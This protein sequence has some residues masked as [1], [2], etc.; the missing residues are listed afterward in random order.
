[1]SRSTISTMELFAMFPDEATARIYLESRLWAEGVNCPNCK[2]GG[3]ITARKNFY[4]RCNACQLD[5]TIRTGTIF[6]RSHIPLQKWV[7]AMY[8]MVTARKGISSLQLAK[9]IGVTQKSAWFMLQRLREACGKDND[10]LKGIV[11]C[12]ETFIGGLE[13]NKHEKDKLKMGRGAVGKTPV[14]GM[15]EHGGRTIAMPLT[16]TTMEEIQGQI[17]ANTA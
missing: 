5:F 12:D 4:H 13:A 11:E 2:N 6:E 15:R 9:E 7:Y 8:L 10:K 1:M 16:G 3:R 17:H 14:L